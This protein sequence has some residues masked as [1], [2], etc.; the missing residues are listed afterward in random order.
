[1]LRS[2]D[3]QIRQQ[4]PQVQVTMPPGN[5]WTPPVYSGMPPTNL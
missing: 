1:V 2:V 5:L 4:Q 3:Y